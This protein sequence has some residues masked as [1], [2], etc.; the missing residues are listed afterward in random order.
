MKKHREFANLKRSVFEFDC[1]EVQRLLIAALGDDIPEDAY[2]GEWRLEHTCED[3][4]SLAGIHFR[5]FLRLEWQNYAEF[6]AE[7]V[8]DATE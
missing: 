8:E 2:H 3:A 6:A 5:P 1:H 7:A 4:P